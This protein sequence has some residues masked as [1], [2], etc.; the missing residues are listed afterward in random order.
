MTQAYT[1][2]ADIAELKAARLAWT[3]RRIMAALE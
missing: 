2:D 3:A 1:D